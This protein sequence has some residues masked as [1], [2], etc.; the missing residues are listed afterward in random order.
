MCTV[1]TSLWTFVKGQTVFGDRLWSSAR[2]TACGIAVV[3]R[4]PTVA[5]RTNPSMRST[6]SRLSNPMSLQSRALRQ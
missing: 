2:H 6:R 4:G 1:R 3:V 5:H